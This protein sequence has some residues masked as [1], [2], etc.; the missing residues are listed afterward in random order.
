ML[1]IWSLV[2]LPFLNRTWSSGISS[3][4]SAILLSLH[5]KCW[6]T[7]Y[8]RILFIIWDAW[9]SSIFSVFSPFLKYMLTSVDICMA[10][11]IQM[12]VAICKPLLYH[13]VISPKVCLN[14]MLGS[15]WWHS[16][17]L[18]MLDACWDWPSVMQKPSTIIFVISFLCSSSLARV[19]TSVI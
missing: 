8:Q 13:V 19:S 11:H 16:K 18:V 15:Y 5:P 9:Q 3:Q 10:I 2:L 17:S 7:L 4:T 1:A 14:L 6:L 12:Y